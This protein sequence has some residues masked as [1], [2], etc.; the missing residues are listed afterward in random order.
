MTLSIEMLIFAVVLLFVGAGSGYLFSRRSS[1]GADNVST[2][3][4]ALKTDLSE[5]KGSLSQMA[6][7]GKASDV[8]LTDAIEKR[9]DTVSERLT[10][11][12]TDSATKTATSMGE[13]QKHLNV[14]DEAQKIWS[15]LSNELS[16]DIAGLQNTLDNKQTRGAFGEIQLENLVKNMLDP[17]SYTLQAT[18]SNRTRVDCLLNYPN[19]PGPIPI[20]AKFPLERYMELVDATD[21]QLRKEAAKGFRSDLIGHINDISSKYIIPGETADFAIMFLPSE[22][23][24]IELHINFRE[25]VEKGIAARVTI[26]S[27]STLWASLHALRA[28]LRDVK[29]REQAGV[30]Q[31]AVGALMRDVELMDDRAGKLSTHFRQVGED[32]AGIRTSAKRILGRSEKIVSVQLEEDGEEIEEPLEGPRIRSLE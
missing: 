22:S 19:P 5:L 31:K 27:P 4:T 10:K 16:R 30:I 9:L 17:D 14:I 32:V 11:G 20:D 2:E 25:I 23:I 13:L 18:L 8:A 21:D 24:F 12:L 6:I 3:L 26:V 28:I 15:A 29:M 1:G 7:E